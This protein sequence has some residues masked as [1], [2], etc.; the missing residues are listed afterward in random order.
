[1]EITQPKFI[2]S[3]GLM[4]SLDPL[5]LTTVLGSCVAVC[6]YDNQLKA[7]GMNHFMLPLWNGSGLASPKFGN[8]AIER[9]IKDMESIGSLRGNIVAKVFGGARMLKEQSH[10]FDIGRRNIDLAFQLLEQENIKITAQST[11][12]MKGR[13][14][15]FNTQTGEV[16]QKYV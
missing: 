1:M 5:L 11:G 12:G 7:G 3:S 16:F 2:Y 8:I 6:L 13:K 15:Y 10:F 4:V 9:L 14:I